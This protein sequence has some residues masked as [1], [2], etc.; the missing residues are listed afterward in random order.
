MSKPSIEQQ[1]AELT[2]EQRNRMGTVYKKYLITLLLV[3]L[4]GVLVTIG[5]FV[6]ANIRET[7]AH[8]RHEALQA[9]IELNEMTNTYNAAL[10]DE[11]QEALDEY[12]D[13]KQQKGLSLMIGSGVMLGGLV[14]TYGIFKKK[15]PYFSEK[16][17]AYLKKMT[18]NGSQA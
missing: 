16:K 8:N 1:V 12:Y 14:I 15:Y 11:S 2:P 17:Y 18:K 5:L 7:I 10:F 6:E 13:S 3:A 9:E 4:A